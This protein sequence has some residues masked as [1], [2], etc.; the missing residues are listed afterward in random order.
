ML[1]S[2]GQMSDYKGAALMLSAM[3]KA[4]QLLADYDATG[5]APPSPSAASPPAFLQAPNRKTAD[6]P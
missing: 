3:P 1:L 6:T 2:E 5:S 4:K